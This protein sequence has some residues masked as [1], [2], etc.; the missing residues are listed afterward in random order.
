MTA[1]RAKIEAS[2]AERGRPVNWANE[3]EAAVLSGVS[4]PTF[5]AKIKG[6]EAVGFPLK[7]TEN[8]KRSIPGILA[9]WRLPANHIGR[10]AADQPEDDEST[11]ERWHGHRP[12]RI[13]S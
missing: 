11:L 7:N 9:F 1:P 2:L 3:Q 4:Y 10:P 5:Q 6:W 13:T 8:G 12:Q